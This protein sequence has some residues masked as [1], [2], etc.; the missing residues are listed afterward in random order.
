MDIQIIFRFLSFFLGIM[1]GFL[2]YKIYIATKGIKAWAYFTFAG[3]VLFF[4]AGIQIPLMILI[5]IPLLKI[6]TTSLCFIVLALVMPLA[7]IKFLKNFELKACKFYNE[8]L[9]FIIYGLVWLILLF[10]NFTSDYTLL[11]RKILSIS[12]FA[13]GITFLMSIYPM[14][15]IM[16]STKKWTWSLLFVFTIFISFG[17]LIGSLVGGCCQLPEYTSNCASLNL[18]I[19]QVLP[20]FC[21]PVFMSFGI[22]YMLLI[23][24]G[25]FLIGIA[26]YGFYQTICKS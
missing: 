2:S 9:I 17:A 21:S 6:I 14:L 26:F 1:I 7:Y 20:L 22:Y 25:I 8:K 16:R 15:I 13:L 10:V 24:G 11:L 23:L 19:I 3:F 4:W 18:D 5:N 12:Q